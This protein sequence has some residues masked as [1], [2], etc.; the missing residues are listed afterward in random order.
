VRILAGWVLSGIVAVACGGRIDPG[1]GDAGGSTG[2][3]GGGAASGGGGSGGSG[4]ASGGGSGANGSG[5][6]TVPPC[7]A[8]PPTPGASCTAPGA[9]GC[10]Y[11]S[12]S[13]NA[14]CQ[15][16]VCNGSS[17]WEISAQGC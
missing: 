4:G 5:S 13:S 8:D 14:V 6:E 7:P 3:G 17:V 16:F 9:E 15:A 2:P 12:G 1:T 11:Y 10:A